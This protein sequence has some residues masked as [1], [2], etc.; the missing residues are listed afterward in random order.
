L[1]RT[2]PKISGEDLLSSTIQPVS[3]PL[4]VQFSSRIRAAKEDLVRRWLDRIT[5]RVSIAPNRVFPSEQLLD[6]VPILIDGIAA[7]LEVPS[8]EI[9]VDM[10]VIAKAME[11]GELRHG[12]GFDAYEILKEYEILGGIL[13]N[14]LTEIVDQVEGDCSRVELLDCGHRL[15]RAIAIIQQ[16]TAEQYLRIAG[17]RVNEREQRLRGF[18][19]SVSHEVKNRIGTLKG[20]VEMLQEE[21][22]KADPAAHLRFMTMLRENVNGL[23]TLVE[24]LSDLSRLDDETQ[25]KRNI[26]LP[27]AIAESVRQLRE[28]AGSRRVTVNIQS[29]IPRVEIPAAVVEL[30]VSNYVANAIKYR[31]PARAALVEISGHVLNEGTDQC[32]V[33]V[34][35]RNNGIGVPVDKRDK[36][37]TRYF[38]AHA[39]TSRVEGT[40]LGLSIVRNTVESIGGRAWA[41]FSD[42]AWT[43]FCFSV[44]CLPAREKTDVAEPPAA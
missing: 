17:D 44:P 36:L 26:M 21:F 22:V 8:E 29:D 20:A 39:I 11:L 2:S 6:H 14:F 33:V 4:P 35:V 23:Q 30:C 18:N 15:F 38:R 12:Q 3:C 13:F 25:L 43:A 42:P 5:D 1:Y 40:G 37:F 10:P 7:Y 9:S 41:D 27:D 28:M 16:V 34:E 24:D 31:E 32:E 19:R